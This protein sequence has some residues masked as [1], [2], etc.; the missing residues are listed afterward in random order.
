[1]I[2][3]SA[4]L[5]A[6]YVLTGTEEKQGITVNIEKSK[7]LKSMENPLIL[8][9]I[10]NTLNGSLISRGRKELFAPFMD[11]EDLEPTWEQ[12][13][14]LLLTNC[15]PQGYKLS[16]NE[17]DTATA[18]KTHAFLTAAI[19]AGKGELAAAKL[20]ARDSI[21]I[22]VRST[23]EILA[24]Y[25]AAKRT[26]ARWMIDQASGKT[27]K[28]AETGVDAFLAELDEFEVEPE[29]VA[30]VDAKIAAEL[31]AIDASHLPKGKGK[32]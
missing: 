4:K 17:D 22:H 16:P 11:G 7:L 5:P 9:S 30:E 2:V 32:A 20:A 10:L 6:S 23:V 15:G 25:Y 3:G 18:E 31:E 12:V 26:W 14:D 29:I 13:E 21:P 8:H 27:E 24:R 19:V 1:M 28:V